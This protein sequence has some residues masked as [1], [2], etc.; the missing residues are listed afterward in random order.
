[1]KIMSIAVYGRKNPGVVSKADAVGIICCQN[2]KASGGIVH[3]ARGGTVI[4]ECMK[5]GKYWNLTGLATQDTGPLLIPHTEGEPVET[6]HAD[7]SLP[8][9]E[10][11]AKIPQ[12]GDDPGAPTG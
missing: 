8:T 6:E 12:E 9:T 7:T 2:R 1:M 4:A 3:I 11:A 10:E 5:C